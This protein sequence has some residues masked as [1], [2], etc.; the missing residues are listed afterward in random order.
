MVAERIPAPIRR[1]PR[2]QPLMMWA[3]RMQ[4]I[5]CMSVLIA[6]SSG[7]RVPDLFIMKDSGAHGCR[8]KP[9]F[10]L[11]HQAGHQSPAGELY[12]IVPGRRHCP[13]KQLTDAWQS[14]QYRSTMRARPCVNSSGPQKA[15]S[16]GQ[17][18]QLNGFCLS[19]K[20]VEHTTAGLC[21][22]SVRCVGDT[23]KWL[24]HRFL[25]QW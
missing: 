22:D 9:R 8:R 6:S 1:H 16:P 3:E 20:D 19:S 14:L 10:R 12:V 21:V 15:R 4:E 7:F 17:L 2:L 11:R 23:Y 13:S 25:S 5:T 18:G 24:S